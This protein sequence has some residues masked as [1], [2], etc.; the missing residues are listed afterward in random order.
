MHIV[1]L[2]NLQ[3]AP[4]PEQ[5]EFDT[6]ETVRAITEILEEL[7]HKVTP[8]DA[9]ASVPYLVTRLDML[10]PDIVLNTA[11]GTHG[12]GREGFYPGLLDQLELLYTGSDAYVCTLTLDKQLTNLALAKVGLQVPESFLLTKLSGLEDCSLRFPVIAKPNFEGSSKGITSDSVATCPEEL[13]VTAARLLQDYPQGILLEEYI[14]GRDVT[15]PFIEGVGILE[16]AHYEFSGPQQKYSIYDFDLKQNRPD[17]V[18]VVC[19]AVIPASCRK[20]LLASAKKAIETLGVRDLG[21]VDFRV[22]PEG[23]VFLIEVNAL[24][25]LEPGAAIY[26]GASHRGLDTPGKALDAI[27]RSALKR[28]GKIARPKRKARLTVGV[29]H[30][31][32]RQSVNHDNDREAEFDTQA[33]VDALCAAVRDNGFEAVALEAS[34]ELASR[35]KGVDLAFNIAEG[36]HGRFREAQVP[37]LLELMGVPCT[38]SEAGSL[39][40]CHDKALAKR[41]VRESG[42]PTAAFQVM[43]TGREKLS[44]DLCFP[45]LVKPVAE[46]SS[47]GVL[48]RS[49]VE[50]ETELRSVVGEVLKKYR[51]PALV[52][53]FLSGREFTVGILGEKKARVLPIMEIVFHGSEEHQIYSFLH[54][55]ENSDQVTFQVPAV[56][57]TTLQAR[58]TKYAKLAFEALGCRDVARIDFR[59]DGQGRVNFIECNPLPGL[60]PG[61]SDLCV[62]AESA[63]L[64]YK[65]LVGQIMTPAVRR[66][67]KMKGGASNAL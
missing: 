52:E 17:D 54:K 23:E 55:L 48:V 57:E 24:P 37:A 45:L 20:T 3:T 12:R 36:A 63:G 34:Q 64:S 62:I 31:L 5:A 51:Q 15:V 26:L 44:K 58:L 1:F 49:V 11:E 6:P 59:L 25:S 43:T 16:P 65:E 39:A 9:A 18:H 46:G 8:L 35:L 19:P 13:H 2:H 40:V 27:L 4:V 28:R 47:K 7:G 41:L 33:T 14:D 42:V 22:T 50:N 53:T 67:K 56:L 30:N 32:K 38:G 60:S 61:F 10:A 21:R 29:I 66:L